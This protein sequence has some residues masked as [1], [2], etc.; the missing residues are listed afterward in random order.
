[1]HDCPS[2]GLTIGQLEY[3]PLEVCK[4]Q[5]EKNQR[6]LGISC[7]WCGADSVDPHK[8][9]CPKQSP[10]ELSQEEALRRLIKRVKP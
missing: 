10:K 6:N 7:R 5:M 8:D 2:C 1:M 3:H 9:G 4:K